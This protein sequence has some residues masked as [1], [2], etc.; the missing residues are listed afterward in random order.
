MVGQVQSPTFHDASQVFSH[1]DVFNG[2][3]YRFARSD[4]DESVPN[5]ESLDIVTGVENDGCRARG[6]SPALALPQDEASQAAPSGLRIDRHK[7]YLG[8]GGVLK[9]R[10]PTARTHESGPTIMKCSLSVSRSSFSEP[11]G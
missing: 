10:R 4:D 5:I 6:S 1:A 7:T 11:R 8:F 3:E 9:C 2:G